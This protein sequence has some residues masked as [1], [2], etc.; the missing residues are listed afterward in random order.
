MA[1]DRVR[2]LGARGFHAG[3]SQL[4]G[5]RKFILRGNVVDLAVGIVIGAAFTA[6][7][8]AL[9][10]DFIKPLIGLIVGTPK[11]GWAIGPGKVFLVGDFVSSVIYFLIVAA[12]VYFLVVEPVNALTERFKPQ[13]NIGTPKRDC[14]YC[15][16]S[17]PVEA[18]RCAFCTSQIPPV[19]MAKQ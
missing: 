10:N 15:L 19:D 14:P 7:V 6:V 12:V 11:L 5:F 13:E 16:S 1:T 4:G 3:A 8:T 9:V 2:N 18:T 17:V